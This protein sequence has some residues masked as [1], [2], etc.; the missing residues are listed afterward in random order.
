MNIDEKIKKMQEFIDKGE[1]CVIIDDHKIV[2]ST[3]TTHIYY[4]NITNKKN[5]IY[6][7][8]PT[9]EMTTHT[10]VS[11]THLPINEMKQN[12]EELFNFIKDDM[13]LQ[14]KYCR[15]YY[16]PYN[17]L[18]NTHNN[19]TVTTNINDNIFVCC[20]SAPN[21]AHT[22]LYMYPLICDY[23]LLKKIIPDLKL[24]VLY[25]TNYVM[26]L[27]NLLNID[28][29]VIVKQ[30]EKII[31]TGYT[32]F[33]NHI[34][35]NIHHNIIDMYFCD[36]IAKKTLLSQN[37]IIDNTE[38][39]KK[40]IFLRNNKNI[41]SNGIIKN[42]DELVKIAAEYEYVDIDQTS[43]SL[44]QT[45]KLIN[46]ATHIILE[47]G[48][49]MIHLL[50]SRNIK[51]IIL[52]SRPE[53]HFNTLA[54]LYNDAH[55]ALKIKSDNS[56]CD[57]AKKRNSKIVYD[58]NNIIKYNAAGHQVPERTFLNVDG[59]IK[60]IKDNEILIDNSEAT[61]KIYEYIQ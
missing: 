44:Q 39:P 54:V 19:F 5:E 2:K 57:I 46:N 13:F 38:T 16:K 53:I 50:W 22:I 11:Y 43:M 1:Q 29:F 37:K 45:I 4:D 51:P 33:S 40:I 15:S 28:N 41:V 55:D 42:R 26:F 34:N 31:N 24:Y 10:Y 3:G 59:Y 12:I 7:V 27:L 14:P 48:S 30:N 17:A 35:K 32:Y 56:F 8:S 23:Y 36:I 60:A 6:T 58:N 49:S 61:Y 18:I 21:F 25:N 9:T 52:V 47:S 20:H